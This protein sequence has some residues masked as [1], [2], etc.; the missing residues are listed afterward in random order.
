MATARTANGTV[1]YDLKSDFAGSGIHVSGHTAWAKGYT[2]S[3]IASIQALPVE[4][5]LQMAGQAAVPVRGDL[6]ATAHVT[7]TPRI[8]VA[9]LSFTLAHGNVY[10]EPI[11]RLQEP[12]AT[13]IG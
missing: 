2:T 7:G 11:D 10:E 4:K 12:F 13:R 9:D 6:S 1:S 8:P 5:A 3:A